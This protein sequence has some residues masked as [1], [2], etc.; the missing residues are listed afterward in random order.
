MPNKH[1]MDELDRCIDYFQAFTPDVIFFGG[2][3]RIC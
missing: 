1:A 3:G 2:R